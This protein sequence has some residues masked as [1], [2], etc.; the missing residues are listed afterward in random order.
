MFDDSCCDLFRRVEVFGLSAA[1]R[2][3]GIDRI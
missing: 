2:I 1:F 3:A